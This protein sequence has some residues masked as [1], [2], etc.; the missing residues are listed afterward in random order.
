MGALISSCVGLLFYVA[1]T[2]FIE[3]DSRERF[4][5]HARNAQKTIV[6]RVKSYTDVLRGAASLFRTGE[7]ISRAQFHEY[8]EG[9]ALRDTFPAIHTINYAEYVTQAGRPAFEQ[10]MRAEQVANPGLPLSARIRPNGAEQARARESY[11]VVTFIEP[12]SATT[13]AFGLDLHTNAYVEQIMLA[14]R[15]SGQMMNSGTPILA[16]SSPNHVFLGLRLPVYRP[17]ATLDT[18]AQRRAAYRGSVGIAFSVPQLVQGVLAEMPVNNVRMTLLDQDL[19]EPGGAPVSPASMRILF[20]SSGELN[21][22][23][24]EA[25]PRRFTTTLPVNFHGRPW[26]I[27]FSTPKAEMY[28][29]F[30]VIYPKLAAFA[31]FIGSLLVYAL[32]HALSSS[33]RR[34]LMIASDMTKELRASEAKLQTSNETLRLLGAHADQIKELERKRIAREIHDDLGQNLLALRIEVD[35]LAA[36]TRAR[37]AHLHARA[38]ATLLQIDATIKSVRQIINDLRPNVLDLGLSAAV[39][40][41]VKEF[42][43]LSGIECQLQEQVRDIVISDKRATAFF[44]ILQES[45]SNIS[46]HAGATRV[47]VELALTGGSLVMSIADNGNGLADRAR[48][49]VGSFGLVGIE[50]R[51]TML[52]GSLSIKGVPGTGTT[53]CVSA[54]IDDARAPADSIG[55]APAAPL[56]PPAMLAAAPNTTLENSPL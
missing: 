27:T 40:W 2:Q 30:D 11:C 16:I 43:R 3:S 33:R 26:K 35:M 50:E 4:A 18:I 54:P 48:H 1:T 34:A 56:A 20:D 32:F 12:S 45:L 17:G 15:D 44:R 31:G 13:S 46:R 24:D 42:R 47:S 37:H 8:A 6:A 49:K 28:T 55:P 5:N 23:P 19:P 14:T 38:C 41:Q 7:N 9:L 52:G 36:R 29:E 53:V 39:E 51:I 10:R 21:V 22:F 25:D